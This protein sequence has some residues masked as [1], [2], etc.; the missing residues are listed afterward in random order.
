MYK[1][2]DPNLGFITVTR[3]KMSTDLKYA[4]IYLSLMGDSEKRKKSFNALCKA[5]NFVRKELSGTLKMK[6]IPEL[7]FIKDESLD[8]VFKIETILKKISKNTSG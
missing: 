5:K 4:K 2:E 3:V 1:L 8:Y 7:Q 6:V